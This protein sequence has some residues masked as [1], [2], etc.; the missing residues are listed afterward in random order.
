MPFREIL[1]QQRV[2]RVLR[3]AL[4]TDNL[5]H[6]YLFYG[7]AGVGRFKTART[8]AA[9]LFCDAAEGDACGSCSHCLRVERE[10][11]PAL[12]VVRPVVRKG[13]KDWEVDPDR[14]EIRIDQIRELQKWFAV[15]SFDGGWRVCILDGAEK[16]NA[17]AANS[18]LKTLEEPPPES[19]LVLISPT[20][21][22]LPPTVVSRCQPLYFPPVGR[23]EIEEILR[24][25]AGGA[26][27]GDLV[28]TAALSRGSVGR[29]RQMDPDWIAGERKGWIRG[30]MDVTGEE[31]EQSVLAFAE[32]L[33]GA[34]RVFD[35]LDLFLMWYRDL[36]ICRGLGDVDR[37]LN[38][39]LVP[40]IREVAESRDTLAWVEK[41]RAVQRARAE[42]LDR[43][44]LNTQ[45]VLETMLLRLADRAPTLE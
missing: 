20:R 45:L 38:V 31:P 12:S 29:A 41:A 14:G 40:E 34:P 37:L 11:H 17:P 33:S 2:I 23:S 24:A 1:G 21:T 8:L 18:L 30:L 43:R 44:N 4:D 42:L 10:E 7:T 5:P 22:Q 28:L 32:A 35:V 13:D 27:A 16:M 9:A 26:D 6:A 19:L 39:D 3:K 15:R 25:D 36:V